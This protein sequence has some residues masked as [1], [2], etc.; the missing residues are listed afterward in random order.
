MTTIGF[1][2]ANLPMILLAAAIIGLIAALVVFK[3][4]IFAF[5]DGIWEWL[6][7]SKLGKLLGWDKTKEEKED[8]KAT[9]R[10]HSRQAIPSRFWRSFRASTN[11]QLPTGQSNRSPYRADKLQP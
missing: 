3:D 4:D 2:T 8:R 7:N 6:K 10:D 1:I 9:K 5:F 11:L